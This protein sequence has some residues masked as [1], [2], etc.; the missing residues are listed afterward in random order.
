[1]NKLPDKP[2]ELIRLAISDLNKVKKDGHRINMNVYLHAYVDQKCMM[3]LAGSVMY[4]T[5]ELRP[6]KSIDP[7][8][9]HPKDASKLI[10]LNEFRIGYVKSGCLLMG[11]KTSIKD[12][13]TIK[14]SEDTH[15]Q[16]CK[17]M[18]RLA[19]LLEKEGN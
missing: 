9:L 4:N 10:A 19:N 17:Q 1:M 15:D 14:Y 13:H 3:C 11:I 5:L 2:S 12:I 16:F 18:L 6:I 7:L 8:C